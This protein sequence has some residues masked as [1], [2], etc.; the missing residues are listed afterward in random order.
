MAAYA[1]VADLISRYGQDDLVA[2]NVS[3]DAPLGQI[4]Q[5]RVQ[6][7]LEDAS[8]L[9]DSYLRR[10]YVTPVAQTVP[11]L[12]AACCKLARFSLAVGSTVV[13][14]DQMRADR[15][16]A[17]AWLA[18]IGAGKATLDIAVTVDKTDTWSRVASRRPGLS[19]SRCF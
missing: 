7:A 16:D 10:R 15:K 19:A 5:A 17:M 18:D 11:A 9:I 6:Q 14:T 2:A 8:S 12:T 1:T 4:D 13:P 3:R